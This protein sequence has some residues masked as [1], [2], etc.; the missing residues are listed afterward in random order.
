MDFDN[1]GLPSVLTQTESSPGRI[2]GVAL[3][4]LDARYPWRNAPHDVRVDLEVEDGRIRGLVEFRSYADLDADSFYSYFLIPHAEFERVLD[5][6]A[7][8]R[9]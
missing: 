1:A 2:T 6:S 9:D 4:R 8:C 3:G 7:A 5:A